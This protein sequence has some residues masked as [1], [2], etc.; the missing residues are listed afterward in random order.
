MVDVS[1]KATT[2]RN[3]FIDL[4]ELFVSVAWSAA[5]CVWHRCRDSIIEC[6]VDGEEWM[7]WTRNRLFVLKRRKIKKLI[8]FKS[9]L[10]QLFAHVRAGPLNRHRICVVIEFYG[11]ANG[12]DANEDA[13]AS[14]SAFGYWTFIRLIGIGDGF[15]IKID[16]HIA[17]R[18]NDDDDDDGNANRD[19]HTHSYTHTICRRVEKC[20]SRH[21]S[22]K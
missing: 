16:L 5:S 12:T 15:H 10:V 18:A 2:K 8:N 1:L 3:Y 17:R 21:R 20:G 13:F 6:V 9:I 19:I 7:R 22:Y 14:A 4:F 11:N